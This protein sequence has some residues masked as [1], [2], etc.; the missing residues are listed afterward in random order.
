ML[1]CLALAAGL[2]FGCALPAWSRLGPAAFALGAGWRGAA[3]LLGRRPGQAGQAARARLCWQSD[4][5][6]WWEAPP[7]LGAYVQPAP[8]C[9]LGPIFWLAWPTP[10]GR[11]YFSI[12][13]RD[14]EPKAFARLKARMRF[15]AP[16]RHYRSP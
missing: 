8:L 7:S 12:D 5:R 4:G 1:W 15:A 11:R 10:G 6:W 3:E 14:M 16:A 13:G 9:R 2:W